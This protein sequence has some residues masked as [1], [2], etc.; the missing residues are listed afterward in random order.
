MTL[1]Q[2]EEMDLAAPNLETITEATVEATAIASAIL[3]A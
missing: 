2:K 3:P 1:H